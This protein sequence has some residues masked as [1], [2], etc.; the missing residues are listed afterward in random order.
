MQRQIN[1]KNFEGQTVYVG[2]DCHL[3]SWQV[4]ILC[5]DVYHKSF[6]QIPNAVQLNSYLCRMFPVA[7]Y[8]AVYEPGFS[9]FEACRQL[10]TL[11]VDCIVIHASDVPTTHKERQQKCDRSDSNK[12][13]K[14]LRGGEIRGID[15]PSRQLEADRSLLRQR[16][17]LSKELARQKNRLKSLLHQFS[18]AIPER[19]SLQQSRS[20]SRPFVEWLKTLKVEWESLQQSLANYVEMVEVLRKE[21]LRINQQLRKLSQQATYKQDYELLL[22][23]PGIGS[24]SAMNLLLQLGSIERFATLDELCSYV[25]LMPKMYES[26][27]TRIVGKLVNRGR[28]ELKI[29][30]IEASWVAIRIDPALM[31]KY[32]E[33]IKARHP[34]KAIIK[35]AKKVLSRIRYVLKNKVVYTIGVVK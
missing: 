17:R 4:T 12:L 18:I 11:G 31:V 15:I 28:K 1:T 3:K 9:G 19:F 35:I 34:N 7:S 16:Y 5:G 24:I 32:Q 2:I 10:N 21:L 29:M 30:L 13:A 26:G 23:I 14:S 22:S 33:L 27:D 6:S 25:G 8:K 20:W